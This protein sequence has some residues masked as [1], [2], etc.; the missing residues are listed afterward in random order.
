MS[1]NG[2]FHTLLHF[3]VK[4]SLTP[5]LPLL[6]F[7]FQIILVMG[8]LARILS[9]ADIYVMFANV[10]L[11]CVALVAYISIKRQILRSEAEKVDFSSSSDAM[12]IDKFANAGSSKT[13][14]LAKRN[15]A[16]DSGADADER[17]LPHVLHYC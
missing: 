7:K 14:S 5:L 15:E 6:F 8:Y 17:S 3:P 12:I 16:A 10:V 11:G 1:E 13:K 2:I 9:S 4:K